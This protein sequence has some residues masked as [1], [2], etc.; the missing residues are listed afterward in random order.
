MTSN[1]GSHYIQELI[2]E[3]DKMREQVMQVARATFRPE[4]LNRIDEI[5]IFHPLNIEHIKIIVDIQVEHLRKRLRERKLDIEL[6]EKA[7]E[8]LAERGYDPVYGARPLKRTIQRLVKDPL[9]IEI[10]QGRFRAGDTIVVDL[11]KRDEFSFTVKRG[12][13]KDRLQVI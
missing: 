13:E 10:L 3:E 5:I 11:N 6:T 9:A 1:I 8:T 12:K 7:K 4:F 2:D